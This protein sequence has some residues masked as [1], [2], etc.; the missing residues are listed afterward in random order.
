[1][2]D[3]MNGRA[4]PQSRAIG[5]SYPSVGSDAE[6]RNSNGG[7]MGN[8]SA[9]LSGS[10]ASGSGA[11]PSTYPSASALSPTLGGSSG[12]ASALWRKAKDRLGGQLKRQG[13]GRNSEDERRAL[14]S[15]AEDEDGGLDSQHGG[16]NH[17]G[18]AGHAGYFG[19]GRGYV[20]ITGTRDNES[21]DERDDS[22]GSI[23][24]RAGG[25]IGGDKNNGDG[26]IRGGKGKGKEKTTD[27]LLIEIEKVAEMT[28]GNIGKLL[29]RGER[30]Q[31]IQ[32][33][34][35]RLEEVGSMFKRRART[36]HTKSCMQYFKD[37]IL[38]SAY[39]GIGLCLL[40]SELER[41]GMDCMDTSRRDVIHVDADHV[42]TGN[43]AAL[44]PP[45]HQ[46]S[47]VQPPARTA[48]PTNTRHAWR[49]RNAWCPWN[50][51]AWNA[52]NAWCS[53]DAWNPRNAWSSWNA[54]SRDARNARNAWN[55]WNAHARNARSSMQLPVPISVSVSISV[56]AASIPS[57][58][59]TLSLSTASRVPKSVS[60]ATAAVSLSIPSTWV[61]AAL[62]SF[63]PVPSS[64][65]P[66]AAATD[67]T[68]RSV[69][70]AISASTCAWP[71]SAASPCS[72]PVNPS[73]GPS[74]SPG[75]STC[76]TAKYRHEPKSKPCSFDRG[77][78][79]RD[80]MKSRP[81]SL[82][83][84]PVTCLSVIQHAPI[85]VV[86]TLFLGEVDGRTPVTA[87]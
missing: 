25:R 44:C 26:Y 51:D 77:W 40:V 84:V 45:W 52:W 70:A 85:V 46:P 38:L 50:A 24:G 33:K 13:A 10:A 43:S 42:A 19:K 8:M 56:S 81:S 74:P 69:N 37:N 54:R 9:L 17:H 60:A 30:I 55:A 64:R 12:P 39:G 36:V 2:D 22:S 11:G 61:S 78:P 7:G 27:E 47:I 29:S 18:A 76:A 14:L 53:W 1:M 31:D 32:G 75:A 87:L 59:A 21:D 15:D 63:K 41:T 83:A 86:F 68:R 35:A 80:P 57:V 58:S 67:S 66:A 23:K 72:R 4:S 65:I 49:S 48:T 34:A 5:S 3:V 79:S 71:T 28:N 6:G 20:G 73:S 16:R 82:S 62:P